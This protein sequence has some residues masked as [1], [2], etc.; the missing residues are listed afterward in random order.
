MS[1]DGTRGPAHEPARV[2][3]P[4]GHSI[5]FHGLC[6]HRGVP[7]PYKSLRLFVS[8]VVKSI[9]AKAE[10]ANKVAQTNQLERKSRQEPVAL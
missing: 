1:W 7:Y 8:F 5:A 9:M 6:R 4:P 3:I 2:E 10:A